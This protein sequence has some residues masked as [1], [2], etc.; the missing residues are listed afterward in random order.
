[1]GHT[2]HGF[3]ESWREQKRAGPA[4]GSTGPHL[5]NT[6]LFGAELVRT[7][8][9]KPPP[10]DKK[11]TLTVTKAGS[12]AFTQ[13]YNVENKVEQIRKDAAQQFHMTEADLAQYDIYL[14]SA[15]GPRQQMQ[16]TQKIATY[17]AKDGD[18]VVFEPRA[19]QY[20]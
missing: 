7:V 3:E 20:G 17:N 11:V 16:V 18:T 2:F 14:E 19:N 15:G 4:A 12:P 9:A 13:T 6:D 8:N 1:L 10:I 5:S